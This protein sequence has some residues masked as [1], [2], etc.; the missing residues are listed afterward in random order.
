MSDLIVHWAVFDDCRMLVTGDTSVDPAISSCMND[1]ADIARLGALSRGGNTWAGHILHGL[2]EKKATLSADTHS[3][4]KLAYALGGIAHYAADVVMKP[5]MRKLAR[6]D[7]NA[8]HHAMEKGL[9]G[10]ERKKVSVREI[11]AYYDTHVFRKVY[12]DGAR[13]PFDAFMFKPNDGVAGK[14]LESFV[15]SLF[16][17]SLLLCHTLSPDTQDFDGWLDRLIDTVQ[18]LYLDIEQYC[19]VYADPKPEK[20]QAYE[21]ATTFYNEADPAITVAAQARGGLPVDRGRL[22]AAVSDGANTGGYGRALALA[23]VRIREAS[24]FWTGRSDALP[25]LKQ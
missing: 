16:Q 13:G 7:W 10:D 20:M 2:R 22:D 3:R 12:A 25:D 6:A 5:I 9:A 18:P 4:R 14:T 19:R 23:I 21:V 8:A 15:R 24:A 1:H 11:S 17:R